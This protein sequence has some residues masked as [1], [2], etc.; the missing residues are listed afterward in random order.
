M[1]GLNRYP[2][3]IFSLGS[4]QKEFREADERR[5]AEEKWKI[6]AMYPSR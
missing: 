1:A 3:Y 4:I 6:G 5:N 2:L